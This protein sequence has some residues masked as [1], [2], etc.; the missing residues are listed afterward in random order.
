MANRG[1]TYQVALTQAQA[2]LL[3][4]FLDCPDL[5]GQVAA[6]IRL[7]GGTRVEEEDDLAVLLEDAEPPETTAAG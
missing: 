6:R 1:K 2:D 7:G 4:T 5:I 3:A